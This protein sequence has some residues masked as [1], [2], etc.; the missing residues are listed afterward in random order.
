MTQQ[1]FSF[2][3]SE[4]HSA[5]KAPDLEQFLRSSL[6]GRKFYSLGDLP[7]RGTFLFPGCRK[8]SFWGTSQIL[9]LPFGHR[10]VG[11]SQGKGRTN[12]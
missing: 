3:T 4:I 11:C 7:A 2:S 6:N 1:C 8:C 10:R 5:N 12:D 9:F